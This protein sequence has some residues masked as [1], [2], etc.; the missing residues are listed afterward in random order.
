LAQNYED[1]DYFPSYEIVAGAPTRGVFYENNLRN[2]ATAGVDVVM[3]SFFEQHGS[4]DGT[5]GAPV[6]PQGEQEASS[7]FQPDSASIAAQKVY[8]D[9]ELLEAF[10]H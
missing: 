10:A 4:A 1:I 2:V 5:M 6:A 7:K 8:C 9:E 3:K